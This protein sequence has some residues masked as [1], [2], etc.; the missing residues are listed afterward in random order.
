[1]D[2]KGF[3]SHILSNNLTSV[4]QFWRHLSHLNGSK[5]LDDFSDNDIIECMN[6]SPETF[7]IVFILFFW[8]FSDS[9][10]AVSQENL[11]KF[12]EIVDKKDHYRFSEQ[13]FI[14]LS[15]GSNVLG[16]Q[17]IAKFFMMMMTLAF[18]NLMNVQPNPIYDKMLKL[19]FDNEQKITDFILL[20]YNGCQ[21]EF[22]TK[23]TY[24]SK[25]YD[26]V[27]CKQITD[28]VSDEIWGFLKTHNY[29]ES[30]QKLDEFN[31]ITQ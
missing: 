12:N 4:L 31:E 2:Q 14:K 21:S 1:M 15:K 24:A 23:E 11:A 7:D 9:N 3:V 6:W 28:F 27:C 30:K 5:K 19:A 29:F 13:I 17:K 18:K 10:D 26:P 16:R 22:V 25:L 8:V 20:T